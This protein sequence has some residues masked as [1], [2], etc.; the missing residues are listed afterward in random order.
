MEKLTKKVED[1]LAK[2]ENNE[3]YK[4]NA[5]RRAEELADKYSEITPRTDIASAERYFGLPAFSKS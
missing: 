2:L 3:P 1:V 4:S 5:L